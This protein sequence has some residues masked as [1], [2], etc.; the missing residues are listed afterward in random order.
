MWAFRGESK[1]SAHRAMW[2]LA[3]GPIPEGIRVLHHCDNPSCVRPDHLYLGT[4]ADNGRDMSARRRN[5]TKL[6]PEQVRLIRKHYTLGQTMD[7]LAAEYSV[8]QTTIAKIIHRRTWK[9][10]K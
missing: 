5:R 9:Q 4:A 8:S 6:M 10:V 7:T 1:S 2:R 3:Y